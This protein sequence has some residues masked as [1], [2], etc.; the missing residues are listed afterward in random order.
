MSDDGENGD[1]RDATPDG[2][3]ESEGGN[4]E[5][6]TGGGGEPADDREFGDV[7]E[8]FAADRER[9]RDLLDGE[10]DGLYAGVVRGDELDY[11]F[12]HR[13]DDPERVGM[14]ALSLLAH[15]VGAIADQAG[16]PPAQVAED[17]G[18]LATRMDADRGP[19]SVGDLAG[20]GGEAGRGN[21][22][23]D[24]DQPDSS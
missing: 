22:T 8:D 11:V 10:V 13:I 6:S 17:A 14:Q 21:G 12:S 16:I 7:G 15:H 5:G 2:A 4:G 23:F 19:E 20:Q 18:R 1:E 3:G 24:D 9:A